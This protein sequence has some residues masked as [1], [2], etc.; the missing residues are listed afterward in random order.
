[1]E[2]KV[3]PKK[4]NRNGGENKIN[5]KSPV[6][7][8]SITSK[9]EIINKNDINLT[10]PEKNMNYL[11]NNNNINYNQSID[12]KKDNKLFKGFLQKLNKIGEFGFN[13]KNT[14]TFPISD[15][16]LN[17]IDESNIYE[18]NNNNQNKESRN[19]NKKS[20]NMNM[21]GNNVID[22]KNIKNIN[23]STNIHQNNLSPNKQANSLFNE[24]YDSKYS[25]KINK[26]KDDYI[27]FL[28]KEFE[29]NAKKSALLD[30]NNKELL[31]KCDDLLH[32]NRLLSDTLN[33]RT[34]KLNKI[35]QENLTVKSQLDKA[36]ILNQKNE[37]KLKF[38]EEQFNLY[39]TSNENY[40]KIIKELKEQI[41]Q[42]NNNVQELQKNNED[43]LNEAEENFKN[44]LKLEIEKNKKEIEYFYENKNREEN[45]NND[46]RI[47]DMEKHIKIIEEKNEELNNELNK[48]ENMFES[49][50][51]ENEKLTGENNLY[52]SQIDQYTHQIGELNTI[53]K[54]KDSIIYNLKSENLSNEKLL[55]KSNSCSLIK[56]DG[57]EFLNEN[58]SKL[59]SD[60]EENKMKIELLNDK[61]KNIDQLEKKYTEIINGNR[62]LILS[63]KL[64][65]QLNNTSPK[66]STTFNY[67]NYKNVKSSTYQK[68][69]NV[70]T[71][72][73][74]R[75]L[76]SPKK[77]NLRGIEDIN[78]TN[79][80]RK[81]K[82]DYKV[83]IEERANNQNNIVIIS[84]KNTNKY[85]NNN[86][87]IKIIKRTNKKET[88][89]IRLSKK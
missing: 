27:D 73:N 77:L 75:N 3:I 34:D 31:K 68:N 14:Y 38:Y 11:E 56:L 20:L 9:L 81:E 39:K 72:P 57:N 30:S 43:N 66:K 40:Q 2:K 50:C 48:K 47:Q 74:Y 53:I 49:V 22:I 55:N 12:E 10:I 24:E 42:L 8:I 71:S 89:E 67:N 16:D 61:I 88:K 35:I 15:R 4:L 58:I 41:E 51:K 18:N 1:M 7:P 6:K 29:D 80:P 33:D 32:D 76:V 79:G 69:Y 64:A 84:N 63:E 26:I 25:S 46:Q 82:E 70:T 62:T 83:K 59:I 60:N 54:H 78:N 86:T 21:G 45:S 5:F 23:L 13:E 36:V 44:N 17:I 28:Q 85:N 37:Q 87:D 65:Y 19:K 52:K